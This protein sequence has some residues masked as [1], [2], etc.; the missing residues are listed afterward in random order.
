MHEFFLRQHQSE[1]EREIPYQIEVPTLPAHHSQHQTD[2]AYKV[3]PEEERDYPPPQLPK[4]LIRTHKDSRARYTIAEDLQI[5]N[6]TIIHPLSNT[7]SRKYWQEAVKDPSFPCKYRTV[8]SLRDRYRYQLRFVRDV[9]KKTME[10]WVEKHGDKGYSLFHTV[11]QTSPSGKKVFHRKLVFLGVEDQLDSNKR[12]KVTKSLTQSGKKLRKNRSVTRGGRCGR[13]PKNFN[14]KSQPSKSKEQNQKETTPVPQFLKPQVFEMTNLNCNLESFNSEIDDTST[15]LE[16]S[17]KRKEY[18][19][20]SNTD[21]NM[22]PNKAAKPNPNDN[23]LDFEHDS[24][25]T[26]HKCI[27]T[28]QELLRKSRL[29]DLFYSC[30]MNI[31]RVEEHLA[32]NGSVSWSEEEDGLLLCPE[33][34]MHIATL[35]SLKGDTNVTERM[36]FLEKFRALFPQPLSTSIQH[37]DRSNSFLVGFK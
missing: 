1:F 8:E 18:H 7:G 16:S 34:E 6:Y 14:S 17:K 22:M 13:R 11:P 35:T 20:M 28:Q 19:H 31:E 21:A 23:P 15:M 25:W 37:Q 36:Q 32:G 3:E 33:K 2:E 10:E 9:D 26:N 12:A 27:E 5:L 24:I 4:K 29:W 30:S